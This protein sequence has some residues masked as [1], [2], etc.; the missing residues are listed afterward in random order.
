[1][2]SVEPHPNTRHTPFLVRSASL[3]APLQGVVMFEEHEPLQVLVLGLVVRVGDVGQRVFDELDALEV[4][5]FVRVEQDAGLFRAPLLDQAPRHGVHVVR[6]VVVHLGLLV[7]V[8]AE[9]RGHLVLECIEVTA[10]RAVVVLVVGDALDLDRL[11][12][13]RVGLE[14]VLLPV[15]RLREVLLRGELEADRG[16]LSDQ[17]AAEEQRARQRHRSFRWTRIGAK[18]GGRT[19]DI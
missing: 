8:P 9:G 15:D 17:R 1:M 13:R 14:R 4:A 11:L 18:G 6:C 12:Q 7:K 16:G 2:H 3:L 19:A 5:G 10:A